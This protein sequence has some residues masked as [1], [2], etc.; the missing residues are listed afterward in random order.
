MAVGRVDPK[1]RTV[2][3]LV[4][5]PQPFDAVGAEVG[6]DTLERAGA[7]RAKRDVTQTGSL[8]RRELERVQLVFAPGT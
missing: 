3:D 2:P 8:R 7:A 4:L 6:D 1:R 5:D